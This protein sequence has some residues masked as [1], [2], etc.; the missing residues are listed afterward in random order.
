MARA[1]VNNWVKKKRRERRENRPSNGLESSNKSDTDGMTE[2]KE[3][4]MREGRKK[5]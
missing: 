1:Q 4:E 2:K 3:E 5:S